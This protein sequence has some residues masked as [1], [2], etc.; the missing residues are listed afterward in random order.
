MQVAVGLVFL[1]AVVAK[2]L[3]PAE[4]AGAISAYTFLPEPALRILS[5][6]LTP[7]ELVV[8]LT[9]V[10]G[11]FAEVG[12]V[13]AFLTLVAFLVVMIIALRR[14]LVIPCGCF[15]R[16]SEP[17]SRRTV[18]RI[19]MLLLAVGITTIWV[20]ALSHSPFALNSQVLDGDEG[21]R[22]VLSVGA[23]AGFLVI[24]GLWI[25]TL[26]EVRSLARSFAHDGEAADGDDHLAE[27]V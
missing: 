13:I 8:A 6:I 11:L 24:A 12:L 10:A 26:P 17:I 27:A 15:G 21:L 7:I 19:V 9:L 25:L 5:L 20:S 23:I 1:V 14:K 22:Y 3:H 4:F 18:V 16:T 2:L